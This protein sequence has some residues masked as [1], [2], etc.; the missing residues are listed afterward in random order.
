[1]KVSNGIFG[2]VS[3]MSVLGFLQDCTEVEQP[4]KK[5]PNVIK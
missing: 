4:V 1:M 3:V 2:I 5:I